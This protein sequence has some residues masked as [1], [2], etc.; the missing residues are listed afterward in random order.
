[1]KVSVALRMI[2]SSSPNTY[3]F[4]MPFSSLSPGRHCCFVVVGS[5]FYVVGGVVAGLYDVF[6]VVD[7]VLLRY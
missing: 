4:C 1:M 7:V 3:T 6:C 5:H 2:P